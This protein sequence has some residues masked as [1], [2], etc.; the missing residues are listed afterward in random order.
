MVKMATKSAKN[1]LRNINDFK[2]II[3]MRV[4]LISLCDSGREGVYHTTLEKYGSSSTP[5]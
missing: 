2:I 4:L 5:K 3:I 1:G